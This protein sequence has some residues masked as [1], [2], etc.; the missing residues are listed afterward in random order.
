MN[1]GRPGRGLDAPD[2]LEGYSFR[3][4]W[5]LV[6]HADRI[7]E[8]FWQLLA[9][10]PYHG[11]VRLHRFVLPIDRCLL[12]LL[13][14][15][16][17]SLQLDLCHHL[18]FGKLAIRDE[19]LLVV[20]HVVGVDGEAARA[21]HNPVLE[22]GDVHWLKVL[23]VQR[24][25]PVRLRNPDAI[26]LFLYLLGPL[27]DLAGCRVSQLECVDISV[28][29]DLSLRSIR[30]ICWDELVLLDAHTLAVLL[31]IA[32]PVGGLRFVHLTFAVEP[33]GLRPLRRVVRLGAEA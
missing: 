29:A 28:R 2:L 1:H 16:C 13:L 20:Y 4:G 11:I 27:L 26:D 8:N 17:L 23:R 25:L 24:I 7:R 5:R 19:D 31:D 33:G 3:I 15:V 12:V 21:K 22:V 14:P 9:L 32:L 10:L 30:L 6:P 18:R